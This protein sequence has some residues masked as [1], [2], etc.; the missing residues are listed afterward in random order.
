MAKKINLINL[1]KIKLL[2]LD[3]DGVM[4]DGGI[5]YSNSGDEFKKFNIQDGYGIRKL[6]QAG[7]QVGIITGRISRIVE[8]RAQ[9]LGITEV[10]QNLDNK[11]EAYE[12]IKKKFDLTD[13]NI[14]YIGDDEFDLAVL[15]CVGFSAAP[16]DAMPAVKKHVHYVCIRGG[17]NG[18][19]REVIEIILK[20]QKKK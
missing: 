13:A 8:K 20:N 7:I 14:A 4:T 12:S 5:Y 16:E 11:L 10:H 9:D 15:K 17:G 6:H 18:A 3:V 2:L 19:V 1:K